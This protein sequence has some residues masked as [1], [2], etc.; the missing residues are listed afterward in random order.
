[1]ACGFLYTVVEHRKHMNVSKTSSKKP[2]IR[3]PVFL[4]RRL[5]DSENTNEVMERVRGSKMIA[6]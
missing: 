2:A 5:S 4:H 6:S 3:R 1:M